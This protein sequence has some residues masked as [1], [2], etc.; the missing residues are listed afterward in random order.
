MSALFTTQFGCPRTEGMNAPRFQVRLQVNNNNN[1][2]NNKHAYAGQRNRFTYLRALLV[3][4]YRGITAG[5]HR[6]VR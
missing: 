2:N 3:L 4:H 5:S 6:W 1:N